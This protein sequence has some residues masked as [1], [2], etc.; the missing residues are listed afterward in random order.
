MFPI[1]LKGVL[2]NRVVQCGIFESKAAFTSLSTPRSEARRGHSQRPKSVTPFPV[3]TQDTRATHRVSRRWIWIER[4]PRLADDSSGSSRGVFRREATENKSY[5]TGRRKEERGR[6]SASGD[7]IKGEKR[8][9]G[10]PGWSLVQSRFARTWLLLLQRP[11]FCD[12][13]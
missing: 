4:L 2:S 3:V 12:Q 10:N 13:Q 7:T 5:N 11:T 9:S 8:C 1:D 6:L